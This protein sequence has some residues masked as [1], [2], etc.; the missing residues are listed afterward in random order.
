MA[1]EARL[2]TRIDGVDK[3]WQMTVDGEKWMRDSDG[4]WYRWV[5][6]AHFRGHWRRT[7]N[8]TARGLAILFKEERDAGRIYNPFDK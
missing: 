4:H 2:T 3:E 6:S 7:G 1:V 5:E 8:Y